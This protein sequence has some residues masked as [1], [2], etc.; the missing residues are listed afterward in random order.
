[1]ALSLTL[2]FP[3]YLL[4]QKNDYVKRDVTNVTA[5]NVNKT[6]LKAVV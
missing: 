2:H 1:M 5:E 3:A 4:P 6:T